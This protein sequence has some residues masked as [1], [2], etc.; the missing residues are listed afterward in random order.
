MSEALKHEAS[1]HN[2]KVTSVYLGSIASDLDIDDTEEK[3]YKKHG[4][5]RVHV[6]SVVE[7]IIFI[8]NQPKNTM[9]D[10]VIISPLGDF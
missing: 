1:K 8:A 9:I 7:S 2:V 3:L 6:K 10:E 5:K 4:I